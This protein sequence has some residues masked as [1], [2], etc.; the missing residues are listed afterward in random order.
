MLNLD[1]K[2]LLQF[3]KPYELHLNAVVWFVIWVMMMNTNA[4]NALLFEKPLNLLA[5]STELIFGCVGCGCLTY[6]LLHFAVVS[7]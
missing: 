7:G 4:V 2:T 6:V 1:A 3:R 5:A